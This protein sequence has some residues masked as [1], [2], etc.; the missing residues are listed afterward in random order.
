MRPTFVLILLTALASTARAAEVSSSTHLGYGLVA[1][2]NA[3]FRNVGGSLAFFDIS[4]PVAPGIDAGLRSLAQGGRTTTAQFYR[5]GSGPFVSWEAFESLYLQ[6]T[7]NAYRESLMDGSG[8]RQRDEFGRT[9]MFGTQRLFYRSE[10]FDA[11][12]GGFIAR[13]ASSNDTSLVRGVDLSM[14]LRL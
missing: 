10:R 9:L 2:S 3:G 5:L 11:G 13:H 14:R 12:W 8:H 6:L 7:L 1:Q 4:A